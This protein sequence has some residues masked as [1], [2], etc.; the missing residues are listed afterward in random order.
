[1][2]RTLLRHLGSSRLLVAPLLLC[3]LGLLS[4]LIA[5]VWS[6]PDG[7]NSSTLLF[8]LGLFISVS[9][10]FG[11]GILGALALPAG[12]ARTRWLMVGSLLVAA[13]VPIGVLA[14]PWHLP[15]VGLAGIIIAV[16][17]D[18]LRWMPLVM[19][20][21]YV[22]RLSIPRRVY[23]SA[24][25]DEAEPIAILYSLVWPTMRGPLV[26]LLAIRMLA[27]LVE[28]PNWIGMAICSVLCAAALWVLGRK[29]S[30]ER[31]F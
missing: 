9:L 17:N 12:V 30:W 10:S 26:F 29:G 2:S 15:S 28:A 13:L 14:G 18:V 16:G 21:G 25:S 31:W 3:G 27:A 11:V 6:R 8:L 1:M 4:D 23:R 19:L 20:V 7:L 22:A 5:G 24:E